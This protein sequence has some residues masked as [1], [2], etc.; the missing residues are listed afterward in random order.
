M[1]TV[2]ELINQADEAG[3]RFEMVQGI[4]MWELMPGKR[5]QKT[6]FR[7]QSSIRPVQKTDGYC[8]CFHASDVLIRFPDGSMKRPDISVFCREPDEE[9]EAI[10]L[11]PEAVIEVLSKGYEAKDLVLGAKFY[12]EQGVKD[13][14]ILDPI[15]LEVIHIA[16]GAEARMK[17]PVQLMFQCGCICDV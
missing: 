13:V 3:Y 11:L 9:D 12:P 4:G 6:V 2:E 15:S 1:P 7:I 14:V 16:N 10:T 8:G 17:S 5:H